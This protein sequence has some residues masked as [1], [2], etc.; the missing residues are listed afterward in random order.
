MYTVEQILKA[1]TEGEIS[2]ID[3]NHL[4]DVLKRLYGSDESPNSVKPLVSRRFTCDHC[5]ETWEI[6]YKC[7]KCSD[8]WDD[9]EQDYTG[10]VCGNCCNCQFNGG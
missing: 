10:D 1:G 8:K 4:I 2:S 6:A 7:K 9:D 5:E 3:V